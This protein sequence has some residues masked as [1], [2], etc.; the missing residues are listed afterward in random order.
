VHSAQL[1]AARRGLGEL[2]RIHRL[3]TADPAFRRFHTGRGGGLPPVYR[4]AIARRLGRYAQLLSRDDLR[5]VLPAPGAES[6]EFAA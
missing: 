5:P 3:L 1:L 6:E 4:A 2:R